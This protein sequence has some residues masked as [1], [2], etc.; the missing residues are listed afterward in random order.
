MA[1]DFQEFWATRAHFQCVEGRAM[2][3]LPFGGDSSTFARASVYLVEQ[4]FPCAPFPSE[5]WKGPSADFARA[6]QALLNVWEE[7]YIHSTPWWRHLNV[8]YSPRS[9]LLNRNVS[10]WNPHLRWKVERG[11][12]P[13]PRRHFAMYGRRVIYTTRFGGDTLTFGRPLGSTLLKNVSQVRIFISLLRW[14]AGREFRRRCTGTFN[15]WEED[16]ILLNLYA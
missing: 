4:E 15:V 1:D 16:N 13:A 10:R 14:K 9:T 7:G 5:K 3:T 12:P 11:F 2:Y 6:A 8:R